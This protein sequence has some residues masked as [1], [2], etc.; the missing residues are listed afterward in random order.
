MTTIIGLSGSLRR[1]SFNTALLR[2]AA[3][4]MPAGAT[5]AIHTLHGIPLFDADEEAAHGVPPAVAALK[6]AI[7]AA[8]GLL[9]ATPEYNNGVPGVLKN[10]IDWLSRPPADI[11]RVFGGRPVAIVGASPGGFGTV[12]AQAAWLPVMRTLGATVFAGGRVAVSRAGSVF[13]QTGAIGDE[14]VRRQLR[15]FL[16]GFVQSIGSRQ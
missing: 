16:S 11:P 4:L 5:L 10:G 7:V 8:D 14:A 2:V 6:E 12:L 15:T 9:V 1:Q 13:D 3:E